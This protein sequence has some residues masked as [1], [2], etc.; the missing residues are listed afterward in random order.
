MK[1]NMKNLFGHS[2]NSAQLKEKTIPA[3]SQQ[4]SP[5]DEIRR[6]VAAQKKLGFE[7]E[8]VY[9]YCLIDGTE[10]CVRIRMKNHLTG[11]KWIRPFHQI[12]EKYFSGEPKLAGGKPLFRQEYW[13]SLDGTLWVVEGENKVMALEKL[14]VNATTT[15]S[16]SSASQADWSPTNG[17]SVIIWPDNDEPGEKYAATVKSILNSQQCEVSVIDIAKL[18]L[19]ES[20]DVIDWLR[21]NPGATAQDIINL[22][23]KMVNA[24]EEKEIVTTPEGWAVH[25]SDQTLRSPRPYPIEALPDEVR[26]A[27]KEA[28]SYMQ[29][30]VALAANSAIGTISVVC[31]AFA[32]VA[33]DNN[34]FGGINLF[35]ISIAESGER[36]TS[37]DN[38]FIQEVTTWD[39][40]HRAKA[41]QLK[42]SFQVREAAWQKVE[43]SLQNKMKLAINSGESTD[44]LIEELEQHQLT[45]PVEPTIPTLLFT[46]TTPEYLAYSLAKIYPIGGLFSSEGG[47]VFSASGMREES[48]NTYLG[49]LNVLWDGGT[50]RVGR[51]TSESYVVEDARLTLNLALQYAPFQA[52]LRDPKKM[53][54]GAGFLARVL[55]AW[56]EST[57]GLRKFQPAPDNWP[58]LE[59]FNSKI[60][61][62]LTQL[63]AKPSLDRTIMLSPE[64]KKEWINFHDRVEHNLRKNG[65][66][67][68]IR[69]FASKAAENAARMAAIFQIFK[70]G[71]ADGGIQPEMVIRASTIIEWHLDETIRIM[72]SISQPGY[73]V[74]HLVLKDWLIEYCLQNSTNV[75]ERSKILQQGPR[76]LRRKNDLDLA[77]RML[78]DNQY[79]S[80]INREG[81]ILIE[82]NEHRT[83]I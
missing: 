1:I 23:R 34:L 46:D 49:L 31:Q 40:M 15:G 6:Q 28:V 24:A 5:E 7:L 33:R 56:P 66:Y 62:L 21:N 83:N 26:H 44:A 53:A 72:S 4:G 55:L 42:A 35:I 37:A 12:N 38:W 61:G 77:I 8:G 2:H 48:A 14:G 70:D 51:R 65:P 17:R 29:C 69:D 73:S 16:A 68:S 3:A 71:N 58:H 19:K 64:A 43:A 41:K 27:V 50:Y 52:L 59:R 74:P 57:Q 45:K 60:R 76:P 25:A 30:P 18:G 10:S 20:E 67:E 9:T 75:I 13:N 63:D 82:I 39:R 79:V 11:D 80:E 22:P 32:N 36:K 78:K 47:I 54:R 81:K